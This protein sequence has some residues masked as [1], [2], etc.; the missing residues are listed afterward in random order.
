MTPDQ[1]SIKAQHDYRN[2]KCDLYELGLVSRWGWWGGWGSRKVFVS[3]KCTFLMF[4]WAHGCLLSQW[5]L[6]AESPDADQSCASVCFIR[7][8]KICPRRGPPSNAITGN[9][10]FGGFQ[11]PVSACRRFP[12]P[13]CSRS[14]DPCRYA[15]LMSD[16]FIFAWRPLSADPVGF[17]MDQRPLLVK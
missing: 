9:C 10:L 11:D 13:P 16:L 15:P 4:P 7:P 12:S 17:A 8:A 14:N 1:Q 6:L 2:P 3:L 5:L